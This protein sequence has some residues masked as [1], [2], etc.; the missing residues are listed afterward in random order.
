MEDGFGLAGVEGMKMENNL[1]NDPK[2]SLKYLLIRF[3]NV[4]FNSP[5]ETENRF[6]FFYY[7]H[8]VFPVWSLFSTQIMVDAAKDAQQRSCHHRQVTSHWLIK[9]I[10]NVDVC[11]HKAPEST[12]DCDFLGS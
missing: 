8:L 5:H 9:M 6:P 7:L 12:G 1:T 11:H 10:L 2:S 3:M 4:P